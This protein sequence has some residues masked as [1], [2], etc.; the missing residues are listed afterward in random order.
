MENS[1]TVHVFKGD[2][3]EKAAENANKEFAAHPPHKIDT[4]HLIVGEDTVTLVVIT[5]KWG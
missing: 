4:S 2:S 3:I 5:T 1:F